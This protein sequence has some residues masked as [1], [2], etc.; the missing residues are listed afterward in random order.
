MSSGGEAESLSVEML[1]HWDMFAE[2]RWPR[3]MYRMMSGEGRRDRF[4]WFGR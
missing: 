2:E 3:V 4:C 1:T